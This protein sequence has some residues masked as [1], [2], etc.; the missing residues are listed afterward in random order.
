V[1]VR[2]GKCFYLQWTNFGLYF[3]RKFV[4]ACVR[5]CI[6]VC[7]SGSGFLQVCTLVRHMK[8][9][10]ASAN[11]SLCLLKCDE[12]FYK[13][14]LRVVDCEVMSVYE[15]LTCSCIGARQHDKE[16]EREWPRN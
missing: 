15:S 13:V 10:L 12:G 6:S 4:V 2:E 3:C 8:I 16:W 11:V 7:A 9:E 5:V 14:F 1:G